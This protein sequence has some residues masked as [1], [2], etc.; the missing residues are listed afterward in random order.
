MNATC[1]PCGRFKV[2]SAGNFEA[3][4]NSF[5]NSIARLEETVRRMQDELSRPAPPPSYSREPEEPETESPEAPPPPP[6]RFP[7]QRG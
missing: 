2:G 1:S 3:K 7:W 6:Q 4:K 5:L